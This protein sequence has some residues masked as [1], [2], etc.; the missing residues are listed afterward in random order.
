MRSMGRLLGGTDAGSIANRA[1]S[2]E[3]AY[4]CHSPLVDTKQ[5]A[6]SISAPA[7]GGDVT[8]LGSCNR[9]V[10]PRELLVFV[11][12]ISSTCARPHPPRPSCRLTPA[13]LT[14]LWRCT[15][16]RRCAAA[17]WLFR[18]PF[19]LRLAEVAPHDLAEALEIAAAQLRRVH[20][21]MD[22]RIGRLAVTP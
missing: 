2:P 13:R 11:L 8:Q 5:T 10:G 19:A 17:C 6:I 9:R 15:A 22:D 14:E 16:G 20:R 12:P 1:R 21:R 3:L 18:L 4:C 7:V